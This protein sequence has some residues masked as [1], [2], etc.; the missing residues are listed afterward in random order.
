MTQDL[1][2]AYERGGGSGGQLPLKRPDFD[3]YLSE[4]DLVPGASFP[5]ERFRSRDTHLDT[6]DNI[7]RGD[8]RQFVENPAEVMIPIS[9]AR[10]LVKVQVDLLMMSTPEAAYPLRTVAADA[11]RDM[12]VYGGAV[13][14]VDQ[15]GEV[16]TLEADIADESME[17][18]V[19]NIYTVSPLTW[20]PREEGGAALLRPFISS[21]GGTDNLADRVEITLLGEHG[22]MIEV[23]EYHFDGVGVFG[24][25]GP[26][27]EE[28]VASRGGVLLSAT[29][30]QEDI[31]GESIM[32]DLAAP[33]LELA[34]R[35][36]QNS[37]ILDKNAKPNRVWQAGTDDSIDMFASEDDDDETAYE[38]IAKGFGER[39]E[40]GDVWLGDRTQ[41]VS[42][43]EFSGN[44]PGSFEQIQS[45]REMIAQLSGLPAILDSLVQAS[46]SWRVVAVAVPAV[47]CGDQCI[48]EGLGGSVVGRVGVGRI[49]AG[50]RMA[51]HF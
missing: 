35:Y 15:E 42:Y 18:G 30:P 20:Y 41:K 5:P 40:K 34:K 10:R 19:V 7:Y 44:L 14:V 4:R 16:D 45:V 33:L 36:S 21:Q 26:L 39:A 29:S 1:I 25:I 46:P 3:L 37:Q 24:T 8:F 12:L 28:R 27:I 17:P 50:H 13:I 2:S 43:L 22:D 51:A 38:K 6:L 31:W 47:F 9:P 11:I 23:R 32:L 48:A 49:G